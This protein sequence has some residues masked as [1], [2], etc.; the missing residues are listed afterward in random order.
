M[1]A[2]IVLSLIAGACTLLITARPAEYS[3]QAF[4]SL[5]LFSV[6]NIVVQFGAALLFVW[7]LKGFKRELRIAY[8]LICGGV[9]M[10]GAAHLQLPFVAYFDH[11]QQSFYVNSGLIILPYLAPAVLVFFG[12]RQFAKLFEIKTVWM[13]FWFTLVLA[14]V[15]SALLAGVA[16]VLRPEGGTQFVGNVGVTTWTT[17]FLLQSSV[18]LIAIYHQSSP[19]YHH[20]IRWLATAR[21]LSTLAGAGYIVTLLLPGDTSIFTEYGGVMIPSVIASFFFLRS[22]YYFKLINE[23]APTA[24]VP[25]SITIIDFITYLAALASNPAQIDRVLDKLRVITATFSTGD[26]RPQLA[27]EQD[28]TLRQVYADIEK[29]LVE[30]EPIRQFTTEQ[31]RQKITK[32]FGITNNQLLQLIDVSQPMAGSAAQASTPTAPPNPLAGNLQTS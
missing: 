15:C 29:Y 2:S 12:V 1:W 27:P 32:N 24:A 26:R 25:Q 14:T 8:G 16:A 9:L 6:T 30:K 18:V 20:A 3:Y 10:L 4:H 23:D 31:L 19:I 28:N 13:S 17:V 11:N 5:L 7:G 21:W 22:G